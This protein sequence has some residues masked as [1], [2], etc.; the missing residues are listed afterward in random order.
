MG[1][2][3]AGGCGYTL[4]QLMELAGLAVAQAVA[5]SFPASSHPRIIV[6]CGPGNNG[7]DG[8]VAARHLRL[9]GYDVEVCYPIQSSREKHYARLLRQLEACGVPVI[10]SPDAAAALPRPLSAAYDVVVDALF[11]FS[12]S[13]D[14][15]LRPP[16]DALV[17]AMSPSA[18]APP[19]VAVDVPS[20]W[21]VDG[22]P[23]KS[24]TPSHSISPA[25]L[26]SLTAPKRGAAMHLPRGCRHF[27]GGRF[28]PPALAQKYKLLLPDF[29]NGKNAAAAG[30]GAASSSSLLPVGAQV[31]EVAVEAAVPSSSVSAS[32]SSEAAEKLDVAG[33]RID[34]SPEPLKSSNSNDDGGGAS[35]PSPSS[36][37]PMA[38]F[39][40]WFRAAASSASLLSA[41][42]SPPPFEPNAMCL[43]TATPDGVPSARMVLM[44]GYDERGITFYTH[45]ASRKGQEMELGKQ[46]VA[47][48][49]FWP[50][51]T[52]SVRIEGS[53][54]RVSDEEADQYFE[55]RPRSS[56]IGAHASRQSQVLEGGAE[57]LAAAAAAAEAKF[58]DESIQVPRPR[59][60]GGYRVSPDRIE[61]W[62][63]RSSRLHDRVLYSRSEGHWK[64]SRLYP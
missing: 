55:S 17:E 34:Y 30:A 33:M 5:A 21:S 38:E 58:A 56:R 13:S 43:A 64:V 27:V 28:V 9:F 44:K 57:E 3:S 53:V 60:W 39:D 18:G 11:G 23:P 16:F 45:F 47:L 14:K 49:F 36:A 25:V 12:F 22:G 24:K 26:V 42:S 61:F 6:F 50:N 19:V 8:L 2:E 46:K 54:T 40:A 62:T 48:V 15:P 7:G 1:D 37:D 51:L 29:D 20:G 63:G 31:V 52:R 35:A 32:A 10:S 4:D 59:G 41:P